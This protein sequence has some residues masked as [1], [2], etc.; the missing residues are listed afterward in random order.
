M[1]RILQ[2]CIPLFMLLLVSKSNAQVRTINGIVTSDE[3]NRPISGVSVLVKGTSTG[4][5][6]NEL[7]KY[8][9][10][11]SKATDV[12]VFSF[13]DYTSKSIIVGDNSTHDISLAS[14][15]K[16]LDAVVV[17]GYGTQKKT[18]VTSAAVTVKSKDFVQ[19]AVTDAGQLLRGKV[20]GLTIGTPSGDPAGYSQ[21]LLRGVGTLFSSTYPL[22][23]IDGIPGG[24]NTVAPQ[25]I[26]SIDVLKDGSAAAIYGTR[27]TNGVILITTKKS[28][29]VIEPTFAYNGYI[30][31]Q[32]FIKTTDV[33]NAAQY[34]AKKANWGSTGYQDDG[35]STDW[36]KEISRP[37]APLGQLH[38]F[39]VRGGTNKTNYLATIAFNKTE[40]III[41]TDNQIINSR[42]DVN[43]SML[44]DKVKLNV[45]FINVDN[46]SSVGFN[47]VIYRNAERYN[48]TS[49]VYNADG[50]YF[51]NFGP[52][53][54]YNPVAM[55]KEQ[56]GGSHSQS[57]RLSGSLTWTPLQ[58]L[59]LKI[60]A[61]GNKRNS[62]DGYG[63]T[64]KHYSTTA[65]GRNGFASK[66]DYES[67][68][69]LMELTAEYTMSIQAHKFSVI[70][71]YSYQ[72]NEYQR[73]GMSNYDFPVGNYSYI[74]NI[75][76]GNA[77]K[78]GEGSIYSRK[79]ASN[80]IGFFGRVTYN[81]KEK[82]LLMASLR[83][84]AA[85]Q[86]VGTNHP[87]GTFPAV[88]VG[89]R[90]SE[91]SFMKDMA[92]VDNLKLR[93]GYGITGTSP[94]ELFL[95][96]PRIGYSGLF[97]INGEWQPSVVPVSNPNPDLKWE[98]K[99]ETNI[100]IDYS[101][102][103]GKING[104]IDFYKRKTVGLL[105]DYQ[106]PSPPNLY[107]TTKA[108]VGVMEN[109]GVEILVSIVPVETKNFTWSS[110]LTYS[111]NINKLVSLENDLYKV[112]N[113]FF[114]VGRTPT[115]IGDIS[116]RV[117]VNQP[118]GNFWGYKVIDVT[119]DGHWIYEDAD[120]KPITTRPNPAKDRKIIGNGLPKS[121][122]SWNNTIRY[123]NFDLGITMRGAFGFQIINSTRLV[124]EVPSFSNY[125]VLNS[126]FDKVFGKTVLN[127]DVSPELNSYY[128]EK[129]DYWKIDNITL[130]YNFKLTGSKHIKAAR[131]YVSSLNTLTITGYKGL[132]PE[133]NQLGLIPGYDDREK[134]PTARVFSIGMNIT[135]N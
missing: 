21:I 60:L 63:Q 28:N 13:L 39:T 77:L 110:T 32:K 49:P 66:N 61:S 45:N 86:L 131:L 97:L 2:C 48:P 96:V 109:K 12:I 19:G 3:S 11:V 34:R 124:L 69:K 128:V 62:I 6:T 127:K 134:Y 42:V 22:I 87:W 51:E 36:I 118:I 43:H 8:S 90:I 68:D 126:S 81:Y 82:Y 44:N 5:T 89:W 84:E 125:N 53:E 75:G 38:Q 135:I 1:R 24:L 31:T 132:D 14:S 120:G 30:S 94:S 73:S 85:S 18:E 78:I 64:K 72:E 130:G 117:A 59:R 35:G 115:P 7:G 88:S 70:G 41:T 122:A 23:L 83:H 121:Y 25:D 65:G 114:D 47:N 46:K 76:L 10:N 57:T 27:G 107:P 26:E 79:E 15:S 52:T 113:P 106:V 129:G 71:G 74:D 116:H 58:E 133:V 102:F 67:I 105:F 33:L 98:E 9:I 55:L 112:T 37:N 92:F 80:L 17:V 95:A 108:N 111:K 29:G 91:E 93:A 40:G 104:S 16:D 50:T 103:K 100:G 123:Q 4:T 99:R 119:D 101:F 20:A 56:F 54:N